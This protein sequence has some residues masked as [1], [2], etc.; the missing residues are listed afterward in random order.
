MGLSDYVAAL[1]WRDGLDLAL[2]GLIT[3]GALRLLRGT[4]VVPVLLAVAFLV[5]MSFVARALDL[6][7]VATLLRYFLEYV[8]IILIVVFQQEL[9]RLLLRMGQRLLPHSRRRTLQTAVDEL[10]AATE[11][12]RRAHVG[13]MLVLE[14]D[15]DVPSLCSDPGVEIDAALRADTLVALAAPHPINTAHDGA[16]LLRD[17]RVARAGLI[18]PLSGRDGLDP[19]FGTRHRGAI[20]LSEECDGLV[21]VL[22]EERGEVRIV[23]L[24]ELSE[25]LAATELEARIELWLASVE[26]RSASPAARRPGTGD[27]GES[28]AAASRYDAS[29]SALSVATMDVVAVANMLAA[30]EPSERSVDDDNGRPTPAAQEAAAPDRHDAGGRP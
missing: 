8:I 7:A 22:S 3:Y 24:G 23:H 2:L 10:V 5:G 13:A 4:R 18:C 19:R 29:R 27:D 16:I 30:D 6:V 12:L 17:L 26:R 11:R 25:P 14:G 28:G 15:L 1:S 21:I 20:G 9:R